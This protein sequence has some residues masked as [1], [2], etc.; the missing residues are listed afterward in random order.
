M[1]GLDGLGHHIWDITAVELPNI[2][3]LLQVDLKFA[4]HKLRSDLIIQ[5]HMGSRNCLHSCDL[6][7]EVSITFPAHTYFHAHE[8]WSCLLGLPHL[9]LGK[10]G[11][12]RRHSIH[13]R[14]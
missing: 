13:N 11:L 8:I 4:F 12:L 9:D 6:A 1:A 5:V 7:G 14:L 2:P 10:F 3:R